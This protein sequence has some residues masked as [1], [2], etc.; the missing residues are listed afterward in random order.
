M[1]ASR[2]VKLTTFADI[3]TSG[4]SDACVNYLDAVRDVPALRQ[5][6]HAIIGIVADQVPSLII[7]I[8]CGT[9]ELLEVLTNVSTPR[10][11][12]LGIEKSASLATEAKRRHQSDAYLEF[13][14][15]DF[16]ESEAND[17]IFSSGYASNSAD[18]IVLNRVVQH[19]DDPIRLFR[20]TKSM[21]R[22]GGAMI[23]S[24]VDWTQ[25]TITHPDLNLTAEIIAEHLKVVTFPHAGGMLIKILEDAGFKNVQE[26]LCVSHT[27]REFNVADTVFCLSATVRRLIENGKITSADGSRWLKACTELERSG[28]FG[29]S[30]PQVVAVGFIE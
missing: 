19:L 21:L 11:R 1:N 28:H 26:K 18:A 2:V 10:S 20:N 24:D 17:E 22:V 27:I 8:G 16:L 14:V 4:Q 5:I 9:G 6:D 13:L 30:I 3:D 12:G 23:L 29:A 15:H 7:E 25:F